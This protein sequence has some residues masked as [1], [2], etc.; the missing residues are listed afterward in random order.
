MFSP[1][2]FRFIVQK[3]PRV[4]RQGGLQQTNVSSPR[5]GLYILWHRAEH[6]LLSLEQ[7]AYYQITIAMSREI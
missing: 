6:N 5:Q 4:K 1:P 2:Y 3:I 7:V